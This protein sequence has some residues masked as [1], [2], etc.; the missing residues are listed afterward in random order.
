M[1]AYY[2]FFWLIFNYFTLYSN[3]KTFNTQA[4]LDLIQ[5][6]VTQATEDVSPIT[7]THTIIKCHS[8]VF[9]QN[10]LLPHDTLNASIYWI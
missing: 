8:S 6:S 7:V 2:A 9:S 3:D 10:H 4:S 1:G 5:L